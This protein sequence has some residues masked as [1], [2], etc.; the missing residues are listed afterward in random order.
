VPGGGSIF[1]ATDGS[2]LLATLHLIFAVLYFLC[3]NLAASAVLAT[4]DIHAAVFAAV[5]TAVLLLFVAKPGKLYAVLLGIIFAGGICSKISLVLLSPLYVLGIA[6]LV[7]KK[8]ISLKDAAIFSLYAAV[9]AS[10]LLWALFQFMEPSAIFQLFKTGLRVKS[11]KLMYYALGNYSDKGFMYFF[12]LSLLLKTPLPVLAL[13]VYS[14]FLIFRR[15]A[16]KDNAVIIIAAGVMIFVFV[17]IYA[18]ANVGLRYI[19]PAYPLAFMFIAASMRYRQNTGVLFSGLLFAALSLSNFLIHP[20]Y[21]SYFNILIGKNDN[22]YKYFVDS[23]LDWGEN[24]GNLA[25][26]LKKEGSPEL[27]L[28]YFG[29]A[30][31]AYYGLTYQ[32]LGCDGLDL[33]QDE[34]RFAH[35]NSDKPAKEYWA[36]SATCLV[37]L[38][39]P[40]HNWFSFLKDRKPVKVIGNNIFVY[41]ITGDVLLHRNIARIYLQTGRLDHLLREGRVINAVLPGDTFGALCLSMSHYAGSKAKATDTLKSIDLS[42]S[43]LAADNALA[44]NSAIA[45]TGLMIQSKDFLSAHALLKRLLAAQVIPFNTRL[46]NLSGVAFLRENNLSKAK[47]NFEKAITVDPTYASSYYNLGLAYEKSGNMDQA[48]SF[49]RKALAYNPRFVPAIRK[50]RALQ[51]QYSKPPPGSQRSQTPS[52]TPDFDMSQ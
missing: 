11:I 1:V 13:M 22:A 29:S 7:Q 2:I 21:Q 39:Y 44:M 35:V 14:V 31:P 12:P 9:S 41:D 25:K 38:N 5:Y 50:L 8:K 15:K 23:N 36:V 45:Y 16:Y 42:T 51:Q 30:S 4:N 17:G 28:S 6:L 27:L 20:H 33:A 49:Y 18:S 52:Q 10:I 47:E 48:A 34:K 43:K 3:P 19:L 46:Y 24:L 32:D 26:Y 37:G 40:D